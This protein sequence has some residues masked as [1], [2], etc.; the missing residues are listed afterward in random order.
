MFKSKCNATNWIHTFRGL[1]NGWLQLNPRREVRLGMEEDGGCCGSAPLVTATD[2]VDRSWIWWVISQWAVFPNRFKP[3]AFQ[4][5]ELRWFQAWSGFEKTAHH[6]Q[7]QAKV[8][9]FFRSL[10]FTG[11]LQVLKAILIC[12]IDVTL[13]SVKNFFLPILNN[14]KLLFY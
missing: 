3:D 10:C 13:E 1:E 11:F 7:V 9:V 6:I 5:K 4:S 12:C 2:T 8:K 14:L